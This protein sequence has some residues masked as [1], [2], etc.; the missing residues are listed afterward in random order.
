MIVYIQLL[1]YV[2]FVWVV[3]RHTLVHHNDK[4]FF[5]FYEIGAL[6]TMPVLN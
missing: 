3:H 2:Q 5:W 6:P 4:I 1:V